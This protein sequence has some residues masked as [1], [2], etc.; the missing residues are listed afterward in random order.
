MDKQYILDNNVIG[1]YVAGELSEPESEKFEFAFFND[2]ELA[3][4]VE[5]E[6]TLQHEFQNK[7]ESAAAATTKSSTWARWALVATIAGAFAVLPIFY[8]MTQGTGPYRL[9]A[10]PPGASTPLFELSSERGSAASTAI[11]IPANSDQ[12]IVFSV[13][14]IDADSAPLALTLSHESGAVFWTETWIRGTPDGNPLFLA[15]ASSVLIPGSYELVI[16]QAPIGDI[17]A[18]NVYRFRTYLEDL[19]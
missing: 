18:V 1:R 4:L 3:A 10:S 17:G 11:A 14:A 7:G 5:T 9:T 15:I 13:P 16:E 8:F 2:E 19:D 6:Q 12:R